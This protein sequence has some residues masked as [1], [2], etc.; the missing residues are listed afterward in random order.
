MTMRE[1]EILLVQA[2]RVD[3]VWNSFSKDDI[4]CGFF[5]KCTALILRIRGYGGEAICLD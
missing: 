2:G 4:K 5:I 3:D 1:E